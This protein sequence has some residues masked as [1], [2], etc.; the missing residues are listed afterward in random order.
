MKRISYSSLAFAAVL[1]FGL[2]VSGLAIAADGRDCTPPV[3]TPNPN[4]AVLALRVFN[5]CPGSNL[6]AVNNY[7]AQILIRDQDEGCAGYANRHGWS[8]SEDG[9]LTP[10]VFENCSH[11]KFSAWFNLTG[12]GGF[13][14]GGLRLSPWWS[15][16]VDGVLMANPQNGQIRAFGGRLPFYAFDVAY[17]ILYQMGTP[18]WM[19][20]KYAPHA[21][22]QADPATITYTIVYNSVTYTSGPLPFDQ[23]NPNEDPPHGQWGELFPA[24]A[25][26]Y[27]QEPEGNGGAAYDL[28]ATWTDIQYM[29]P[30][31]TPA[32][33]TTW[34]QLKTMYR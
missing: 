19:E 25:G 14:E 34:G 10:A 17:G 21:L 5:D 7:P 2:V 33:H 31:A 3:N 20:I 24:R 32:Q 27:F 4:G 22:S 1:V 18:I 28:T 8:L 6:T 12:Q 30:E 16:D 15:Q 26:G 23:G 13:S 9:G 29:G 11:Y